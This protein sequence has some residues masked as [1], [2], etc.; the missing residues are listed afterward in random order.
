M[1]ILL[2]PYIKNVLVT[3]GA[4]FIGGAV[5]RKL[6]NESNVK[7]YNLDKMNY[8]SDLSSIDDLTKRSEVNNN[9][10]YFFKVDLNDFVKTDEVV[11]KAEPDL[12]IHLAAESHVDRSI[13]TPLNFL[14]SNVI[15][16]F[17]ILESARKYWQKLPLKRKEIFRLI[18]V[19]TDEVFGSLGLDGY[20]TESSKYSPRSPYSATKAASDHLVK[21]WFHTYGLPTIITNCSNNYGPW[22]YP[23]KL[24]PMVILKALAN[25]FI[26]IYGD[27][28]NIRDWIFVEDHVEAILLASTLG[29]LGSNYCIGGKEERTNK[30]VAKTICRSLEKK[31]PINNGYSRL[32]KFVNDRPGHDKRYGID[33]SKIKNDLGWEPKYNFE[34]GID[35]TI[36]WYINNLDWCKKMYAKSNYSGERIGLKL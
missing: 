31:V 22:Q 35:K 28:L 21:A 23:E 2:P 30:D 20:F 19:S 12:I 5:I 7:V 10:Y 32:I 13:S 8:A 16:T 18:H 25:E 27:G 29:K 34:K 26:P 15:G 4:G 3:G 17:N 6:L 36:N 33:F 14:N 24:I 9:R 11:K 1:T